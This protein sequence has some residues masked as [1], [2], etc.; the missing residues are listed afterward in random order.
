MQEVLNYSLTLHWYHSYG[1]TSGSNA[2]NQANF[3]CQVVVQP[4]FLCQKLNSM[5][6]RRLSD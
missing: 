3:R 6:D 2:T 4:F 5:V 1:R